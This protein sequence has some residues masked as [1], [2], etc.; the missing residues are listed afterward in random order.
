MQ[1]LTKF[2]FR[3]LKNY[4]IYLFGFLIAGVLT[5]VFSSL[6]PYLIKKIIDTISFVDIGDKDFW[7]N[8]IIPIALYCLSQSILSFSFRYANW[9]ELKLYP[10]VRKDVMTFMYNYT[11]DHSYN[12][13]QNQLSGNLSNKISE[14]TGGIVAILTY[15]DELWVVI[16]TIIISLSFM[17]YI[18]PIFAI[19]LLIWVLSFCFFIYIYSHKIEVLSKLFAENRSNLVGHL[20][21][22]IANIINIKLFGREKYELKRLEKNLNITVQSD[23]R[24]QKTIIKMRIF[25][26]FTVIFLMGCMLFTLVYFYKLDQIT[27]GDFTFILM[28]TTNVFQWVWF[29]SK[30]ITRIAEEVGKCNQ[31]LNIINVPH[32]IKEIKGARNLKIKKGEILY[33][34]VHFSYKNSPNELFQDLSIKIKSGEKIGLVGFS[35]AGK[36]SFVQLL[37][38]FFDIQKGTILIDGQEISEVTLNSLREN[39]STIPQDTILFHRS[40]MENIRYGNLNA[41]D[42]QVI[43]ASKLAKCH[44]FIME[45]NGDYQ[46]LV[47]ERGLKL[48]GGQ[49]QRIAIARVFLKDS[50]ILILDES[51]SALD[52]V[53]E[54]HIQSSLNQ[55]MSNKTTIVIAHRLSTLYKMDNILVFDNGKIVERGNHYDLM[56]S[57]G[58]Y[59]KMWALQSD[60]F[61]PEKPK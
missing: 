30:H 54:K 46:A 50:D 57:G 22:S 35:G 12:Y 44:D 43:E 52:S 28:I 7:K 31:S 47:G 17:L 2:T 16:L 39:I 55:L 15:F 42:E 38:R 36:T 3:I 9:I 18:Q 32:E 14:M 4:K 25:L 8:L 45:I 19:I 20:V 29:L 26:D 56:D 23:I 51:T 60:G 41:S 33:K 58:H 11:K 37:L 40:L 53:T 21:D 59:S 10:Y 13:F 48:S 5:A 1:S 61:L 27:I 49:R 6:S 34:N 24:V